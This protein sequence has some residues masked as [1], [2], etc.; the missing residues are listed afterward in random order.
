MTET[1]REIGNTAAMITNADAVAK[2]EKKTVAGET[3]TVIE[4][5]KI[6]ESDEGK[7]KMT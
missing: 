2:I 5:K 1:E 7:G 6:T 3:V 4:T